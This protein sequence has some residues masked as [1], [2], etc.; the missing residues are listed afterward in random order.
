MC[1]CVVKTPDFVLQLLP[2]FTQVRAVTTLQAL[3]RTSRQSQDRLRTTSNSARGYLRHRTGRRVTAMNQAGLPRLSRPR[4]CRWPSVDDFLEPDERALQWWTRSVACA[5]AKPSTCNAP[6][7]G[8]MDAR[9]RRV[10]AQCPPSEAATP[11][12]RSPRSSSRRQRPRATDAAALDGA[13]Q[14]EREA[15]DCLA[16]GRGRRAASRRRACTTD[17]RARDAR[18]TCTGRCRWYCRR[19]EAGAGGAR[20]AA[21]GTCDVGDRTVAARIA[22]RRS[23]ITACGVSKGP[24]EALRVTCRRN[25]R[26]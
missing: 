20:V 21:A 15:R 12:W 25:S 2:A 13:R 16:P 10:S 14:E 4:A 8:L 26:P 3:F 18:D 5:R 17:R 6:S 19:T 23:R 1:D 24:T 11:L 9:R 7:L 22:T